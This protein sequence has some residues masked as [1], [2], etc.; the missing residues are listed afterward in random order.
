VIYGHEPPSLRAYTPG[1]ARLPTVHH[2]L[3]KRDEFI[4]QVHE[5]LKQAQ[6]HYKLQ[7]DR[8]HRELEFIPSV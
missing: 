5:R 3:T 7:Y 6:N 1:E 8:N 2:Q 4:F